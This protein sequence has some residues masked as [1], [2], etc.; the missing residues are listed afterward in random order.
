MEWSV[1]AKVPLE[2]VQAVK[3]KNLLKRLFRTFYEICLVH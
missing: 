3:R 2:F 1:V